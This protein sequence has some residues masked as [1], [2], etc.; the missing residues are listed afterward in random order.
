MTRRPRTT[1]AQRSRKRMLPL[2]SV[3]PGGGADRRLPI[4]W[5]PLASAAALVGLG[6]E[7]AALL[8]DPIR[9]QVP[10]PFELLG[11]SIAGNQPVGL[12]HH[13][14]LAVAFDLADEHRLG[15]MV[16]GQ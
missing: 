14:E 8:V 16:V 4:C 5:L 15:D 13:V 10:G 9:H 1:A 2:F 3:M 6:V 11:P 7:V 12:P